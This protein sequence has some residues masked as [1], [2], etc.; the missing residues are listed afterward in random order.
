[1]RQKFLVV[2]YSF[3]TLFAK[4]ASENFI[5]DLENH[6]YVDSQSRNYRYAIGN[7]NIEK[8]GSHIFLRA[9]YGQSALNVQTNSYDS[10]KKEWRPSEIQ[11][12]SSPLVELL[13]D[14]QK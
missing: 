11:G 9:T 7:F 1:M 4:Q 14:P 13:I 12:L 2:R 8:H 3:E 10:E 6:P 5:S